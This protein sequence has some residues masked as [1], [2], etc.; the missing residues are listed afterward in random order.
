MSGDTLPNAERAI[1]PKRK[2][3]AYLLSESHPDGRP[4]ARFF[5]AFGFLPVRWRDLAT[6]LRRRAVD[7]PVIETASTAFGTRY[8]VEGILHTPDGRTPVVRTV[9]F[10]ERGGGPPRLVTAYP[11]KRR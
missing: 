3:V 5:G 7:S 2:I 8:L 4:K 9:W 10:V 6:A 11:G 1:V